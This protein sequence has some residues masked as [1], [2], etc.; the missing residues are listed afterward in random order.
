MAPVEIPVPALKGEL[1]CK[2]VDPSGHPTNVIPREIKW[3][4]E[5][6][7]YMEGAL[8]PTLDGTWYLRVTLESMGPGRELTTSEVTADYQADGTLSG[9]F[10]NQR[11][12][13]HSEVDFAANS[14]NIGS[15]RSRAYRGTALLTF[16]HPDGSP[17]PFAAVYD[18]GVIQ[19]YDSPALP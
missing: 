5:A 4:V 12:S 8:A 2:I 3:S 19:V 14:I 16:T 1:D 7:F 10:P 9:T 15:D 17:G 11:M 18:L 6:D 13:F